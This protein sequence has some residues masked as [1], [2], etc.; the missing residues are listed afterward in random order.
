M[1]VGCSLRKTFYA[2]LG[3]ILFFFF[4]SVWTDRSGATMTTRSGDARPS[5]TRDSRSGKI[6]AR[7]AQP[8]GTG[9]VTWPDE[10]TAAV[11]VAAAATASTNVASITP[12][13]AKAIAELAAAAA[14][15]IAS[16]RVVVAQ[17]K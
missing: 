17:A 15:E 11:A 7:C 9:W 8:L 5:G 10:K 1:V 4:V 3:V 13:A 16:L 2:I 6:T 14:Q 12:T